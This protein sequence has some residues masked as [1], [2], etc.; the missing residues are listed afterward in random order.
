MSPAQA[1]AVL[2]SL[3][4]GHTDALVR[5]IADSNRGTRARDVARTHILPIL[6][7]V[8]VNAGQDMDP[9]YIAYLIEYAHPVT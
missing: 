7:D 2:D 4:A 9:T 1:R 5:A 6:H 8:E 3:F